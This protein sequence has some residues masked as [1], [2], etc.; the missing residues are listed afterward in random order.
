VKVVTIRL[1]VREPLAAGDMVPLAPVQSHY[2]GQVMRLQP[3]DGVRLFN[4]LDGE[5]QAAIAEIGRGSGRLRVLDRLASQA[6][7]PGPWLAFAPVKKDAL[8]FIVIKATEL[9]AARLMPVFSRFTVV[10]R[11][12]R[13]RLA[14]NAIEAAEQC[15]RLT[16]PE[17]DPPTTLDALMRN[18]PPERR[19]LV[20][21][22]RGGGLRLREACTPGS[23]PPG[24][25][26]GPEGGLAAD[27][28]DALSKL[29]F[30]SRITLGR[31]I[32]RAE[33]AALT[34]L[35]CWQALAGE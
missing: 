15:G 13:E 7:E 22:P 21:D 16:V 30:V 26:I 10:N 11:V 5:W 28:L 34:A 27:E 2:L 18:W 3:G 32:L 29:Q 23:E 17:I 25:L 35:A 1:F 14:A 33:T 24:F 4:G 31:R 8:D 9:G 12:N 20:C 6:A 19:L